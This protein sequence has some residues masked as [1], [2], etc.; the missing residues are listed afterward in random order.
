MYFFRQKLISPKLLKP[1]LLETDI[2]TMKPEMTDHPCDH[3]KWSYMTGDLLSEVEI[4]RIV[5]PC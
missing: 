4:S 5:G 1:Y 2:I 3:R